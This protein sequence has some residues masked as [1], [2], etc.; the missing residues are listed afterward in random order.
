MATVVAALTLIIDPL[1]PLEWFHAMRQFSG[2]K[3]HHIP[4]LVPGG[5][6]LLLAATQW[7]TEDGRLLLGMSLIPQSMFFYDQ[8]ALGLLARTFRQSLVCSLWS[9]AVMAVAYLW[10]PPTLDT[11]PK[12]A[13]YLS[14]VILWGYYLPALIAVVWR[15]HRFRNLA[16]RP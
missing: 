16:R 7:R 5:F 13:A 3:M 10:A 2:V 14:R 9:Y 4:V 1:W 15:D 6:L 12:N 11:L 8:L